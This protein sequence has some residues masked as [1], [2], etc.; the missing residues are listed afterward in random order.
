MA[1][2]NRLIVDTATPPIP[3]A[4]GW[5]AGYSGAYG[6]VVNLSQA[7]PGDPPPQSFLA[8]LSDAAALPEA[9][10][11]GDIFGDR[12]LREAFAEDVRALYGA[13]ISANE[14]AITAG[15]NQA[16]FVSVMAVAK[17]GDAVLLPAPWYFNHKMTLDMLGIEA[18]PLPLSAEDRFVPDARRAAELIDEK[19]KAVVLVTPNNPT[20]A[21]YPDTTLRAFKDLCEARG[22]WL[23]VDETYRDFLPQAGEAPHTL[24]S[25]SDWRKTVV[26]LYSFSKAYAIPGHRVGAIIASGDFIAEAGKILDCVQISPPRVPQLALPWAIRELKDWREETRAAILER[27]EAFRAA[28]QP[29]PA[30]RIDQIGAYFAYLRHPYEGAAARDVAAA[31]ARET[32]VLTLPGSY[33]G[34]G[35]EGHLR[36]AFANVDAN[37]LLGLGERFAAAGNLS[38]SGNIACK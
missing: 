34:P 37:V 4:Q 8:R 35:Q 21:V 13:E 26:S 22:I 17:A 33:F 32:G 24:F 36:V 31:L 3:E 5:L 10:K 38:I 14:T 30:W 9:A 12:T 29:F 2:V 15:C 19:V 18:R 25:A 1:E 28:L 27:I 6:P 7:V 11:Y 16:F 20:G 23:I